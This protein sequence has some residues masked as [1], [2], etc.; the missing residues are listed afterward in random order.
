[1]I[2]LAMRI[3][4]LTG[5]YPRA[6]DTFIQREVNSLRSREIFV[7]T[8]AVRRPSDSQIVGPEQA[9]EREQTFYLLPS[10][11]FFLLWS[12]LLLFIKAPRRYVSTIGIALKTS[13]P[14]LKGI[15][16]QVFYFI[17]AGLL[18]Y[19]IKKLNIQHLHNHLGDSSCSV[20]MLAAELGG[21]SYSFTLH[22]PYIFYEPYRWALREKI[23]RAKFVACISHFCRSQAMYFSPLG[24]WKHLPIVHCGVDPSLFQPAFHEEVGKNLLCIGRISA[25]K[26]FPILLESLVEIKKSVPCVHLTIVGDGEDRQA[27]ESLSRN[28]DLGEQIT[29]AGYQSQAAVRDYIQQADVFVLPSFAEGV[30]VSLMEAMAAGVPV[31]STRIAGISELV[32]ENISGYLIPP[33]DSEA[34]AEKV[35]QLLNSSDLRT[36]FGE[37]GRKKVCQE[38]NLN[39][40]AE[41]LHQVMM[42]YLSDKSIG[43]RP[44][45]TEVEPN[46]LPA[47]V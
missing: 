16:Y 6:T 12:H 25:A 31:V 11:L 17:E 47:K 2:S 44:E 27:L 3:A 33:G 18:A 8:F 14:G 1:M 42:A 22:G 13:Q 45:P 7:Q 43:I 21:F 20:A 46:T 38:F 35:V 36:A 15:S 19:K 39:R 5:T 40:E 34:L 10:N 24:C 9:N 32:E 28:L 41:W 4:Y 23:I 30:P 37:A 29:F 26:G